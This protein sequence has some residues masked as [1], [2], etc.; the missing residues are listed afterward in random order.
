MCFCKVQWRNP[1]RKLGQ[2]S[3]RLVFL[4]ELC[5]DQVSLSLLFLLLFKH[6]QSGIASSWLW[7]HVAAA[8]TTLGLRIYHPGF[9][10]QS[11]PGEYKEF[12]S[13]AN[14]KPVETP[15]APHLF[16]KS[17]ASGLPQKHTYAHTY[18]QSCWKELYCGPCAE[19]T[20]AFHHCLMGSWKGHRYLLHLACLCLSVHIGSQEVRSVR[21]CIY[22]G[23]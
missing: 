1:F 3:L 17:P 15:T 20:V 21:L 22:C 6:Q 10:I 8:D 12:L 4:Y 5:T 14:I 23:I 18:T 19:Q 7:G 9:V 13:A 2:A 11:W 16:R